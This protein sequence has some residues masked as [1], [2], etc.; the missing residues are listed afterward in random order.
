MEEDVRR[1]YSRLHTLDAVREGRIYTIRETLFRLGPR[2]LTG[3][4]EMQAA[5]NK[6]GL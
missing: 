2:I 1:L 4:E 6:S 5:V 3:L